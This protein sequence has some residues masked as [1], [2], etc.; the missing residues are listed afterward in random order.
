VHQGAWAHTIR[1][2][3]TPNMLRQRVWMSHQQLSDHTKKDP[4]HR[5]WQLCPDLLYVP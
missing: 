1:G 5:F 3:G 4:L 2:G